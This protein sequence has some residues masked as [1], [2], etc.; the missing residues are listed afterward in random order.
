M[1]AINQTFLFYGYSAAWIIVLA[2]VLILV[3]RGRRI[4]HEL[5]RLKALVED[6]EK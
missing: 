4:D 3:R 6:K 2:F 1:D 5:S